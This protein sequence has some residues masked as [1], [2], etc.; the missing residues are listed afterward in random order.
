MAKSLVILS[1]GS[2][3]NATNAEVSTDAASWTPETPPLFTNNSGSAWNDAVFLPSRNRIVAITT[4]VGNNNNGIATSD[5]GGKTWI[6]RHNGVTGQ[7]KIAYSPS[8]DIVVIVGNGITE[9]SADGGVTWTAGTLAEANNMRGVDWSPSLGLFCAVSNSGTHTVQTSTDG[10]NWSVQT[11]LT[12]QGMEDIAW[13]KTA[14]LFAVVSGSAV[15]SG[16]IQ[17]SPDGVNWTDHNTSAALGATQYNFI[18]ADGNGHFLITGPNSGTVAICATNDVTS[19]TKTNNVNGTSNRNLNPFWASG[20]SLWVVPGN[21]KISTA[22]AAGT[23]WTAQTVLSQNWVTGLEVN[24]A[25]SRS[26]CCMA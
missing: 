25:F 14:A 12:N 20:V 16:H 10:K 4:A 7:Y 2:G 5:D 21:N 11:S 26:Q 23:S 9:W 3:T 24:L 1:T 13:D 22:A 18:A 8:L 17:S 15:G 19:W 6:G